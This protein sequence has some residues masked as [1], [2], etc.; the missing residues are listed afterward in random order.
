MISD[1]Q[2][3]GFEFSNVFLPAETVILGCFWVVFWPEFAKML[4]ILFEILTSD[5]MQDDA[6]DM[7]PFLLKYSEMVKNGAKKLFFYSYFVT[8]FVYAL[9]HPMSYPPRFCQMKEVIKVYICGKFLQYIIC[10]YEVKDFQRF[11]Y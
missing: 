6:S 4:P 2:F 9:L 7:L 11:S 3:L 10:G 8:F 5:D 1:L